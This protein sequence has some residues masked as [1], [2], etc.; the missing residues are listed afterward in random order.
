MISS[1]STRTMPR[2]AQPAARRRRRSM[3]VLYSVG[4]TG[5]SPRRRGLAMSIVGMRYV[6]LYLGMSCIEYFTN[7]TSCLGPPP[8]LAHLAQTSRL[9]PK[10]RHQRT[11]TTSQNRRQPRHLPVPVL[12][13]L[14]PRR[15][16]LSQQQAGKAYSAAELQFQGSVALAE[17]QQ[18]VLLSRPRA[19]QS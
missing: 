5:Q 8:P 10:T 6:V 13:S 9:I 11:K 14:L 7:D 17:Q 4:R 16:L 3:A 2:Q 15:R 12:P 19:L 1:T 18:S